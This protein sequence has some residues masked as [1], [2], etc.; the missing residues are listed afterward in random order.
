MVGV[1]NPAANTTVEEQRKAAVNARFQL[2]PG[3]PWPAEGSALA[4]ETGSSAPI[5]TASPS[6]QLPP[7]PN[8]APQTPSAGLIAGVVIGIAAA[9]VLMATLC[10]FFGR[11]KPAEDVVRRAVTGADGKA[12][13]AG[14]HD[15]E[16]QSPSCAQP[17]NADC[18][19]TS[20]GPPSQSPIVS[21]LSECA[22]DRLLREKALSTPPTGHPAF[23]PVR[24][25]TTYELDGVGPAVVE[26]GSGEELFDRKSL[27]Q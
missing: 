11:S 13:G 16:T 10:Y 15:T 19:V 20:D 17:L 22:G 2:S 7:P 1:I 18:R 25:T 3:E 27:S 21:P 9:A 5:A 4:S 23:N 6:L 8:A 26:I 14:R 12:E 24:R